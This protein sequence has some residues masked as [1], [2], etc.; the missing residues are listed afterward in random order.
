MMTGF[1]SNDAQ[2]SH[3]LQYMGGC[4]SLKDTLMRSVKAIK[5]ERD[6]RNGRN[7]GRR[8]AKYAI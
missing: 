8:I 6:T 7:L 5:S 1:Q 4:F 2:S 3:M